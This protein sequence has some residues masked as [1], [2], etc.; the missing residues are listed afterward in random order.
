VDGGSIFVE[1]NDPV[2]EVANRTAWP[3]IKAHT[4][5][6]P[7]TTSGPWLTRDFDGAEVEA[8]VI[9]SDPDLVVLEA[10][11]PAQILQSSGPIEN[12][13]APNW[14]DIAER[15]TSYDIGKAVA[16]S[17]GAFQSYRLENGSW[18]LR[19]DPERAAP[20]IERGWYVLPYVY[21]AEHP[22]M[23][24]SAAKFYATHYGP[25][26]SHCECVLGCYSGP[27]GSFTIDSP[28][29]EGYD[30]Q[31]GASIWDLGSVI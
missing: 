2:V 23:T 24:V 18:F 1:W 10:E 7:R 28:A 27:F 11:V 21:P 19:P 8:A 5:A 4:D 25:E 17:W 14:E 9:A 26:W 3:T 30:D 31:P 29:F 16:T 12:P 22:G 15:L 20:L 6:D 13:Q